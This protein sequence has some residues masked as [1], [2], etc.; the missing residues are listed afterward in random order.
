MYNTIVVP[1]DGGPGNIK[2]ATEA[3]SLAEQTTGESELHIL[4]VYDNSGDFEQF[5]G[6][7]F[8]IEGLQPILKDANRSPQ[9]DTRQGAAPDMIAEYASEVSA[10][11]IVMATEG[12]TGV[13]RY[14]SGSVTEKTVRLADCPVLALHDDEPAESDSQAN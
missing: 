8:S 13:S 4:S 5:D 7:S 12:R 2:S 10:D 1:V 6:D 9:R 14:L 11:L 3:I